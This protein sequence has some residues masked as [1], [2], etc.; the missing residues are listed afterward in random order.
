MKGTWMESK[1]TLC[2]LKQVSEKTGGLSGRHILRMSDEGK[3]P[4]AVRVTEGSAH[5]KGRIAFVESEVDDWI[6]ARIAE[7][8]REPRKPKR[9]EGNS[10]LPESTAADRS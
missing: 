9:T 7:R 2:S 1:A 4:Q 8:R 6:E 5:R 10:P 3:F